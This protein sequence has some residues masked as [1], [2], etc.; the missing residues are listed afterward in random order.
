MSTI[1]SETVQLQWSPP[2]LEEQNGVITGYSVTVTRRDTGSQSQLLST[3]TNIT[4]T[5]LDP[6]T[7]YVVTVSAATSVGYGP[8]STQLSF[9]TDEDGM[10]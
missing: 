7:S 2:V 5:M 6:F 9:T 4:I 1:S 3:S 10:L 8:Q